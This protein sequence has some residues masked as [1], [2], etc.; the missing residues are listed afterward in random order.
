[1]NT[2]Y[3]TRKSNTNGYQMKYQDDVYSTVKPYSVWQ[4]Y[5]VL[6]GLLGVLGAIVYVI[7][8]YC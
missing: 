8:Q 1:M 7:V 6:S 3:A 2:S 5:A 4:G